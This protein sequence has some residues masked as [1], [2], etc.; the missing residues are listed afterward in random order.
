[1]LVEN[2]ISN[3]HMLTGNLFNNYAADK[4]LFFV[5][6]AVD[7]LNLE[8]RTEFPEVETTEENYTAIPD[9]LIRTVLC[10][11]VAVK[12]F[13]E[14]D[15]LDQQFAS[16]KNKYDANIAKWRNDSTSM[17]ELG[18]SLESTGF[19]VRGRLDTLQ[20]LRAIRLPNIK[21]AYVIGTLGTNARWELWVYDTVNDYAFWSKRLN[22]IGQDAYNGY[23][24]D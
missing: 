20:E 14:S 23:L 5:N 8:L 16:F 24:Q 13:E 22:I 6:T 12:L 2:I 11:G 10:Y 17:L 3:V 4:M 21:D 9:S 18:G 1:M 19:I 7:E 15:E